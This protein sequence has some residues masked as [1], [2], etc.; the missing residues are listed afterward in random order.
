MKQTVRMFARAKDLAGSDSV[1][2][3]TEDE[4]TVA[5][6]KTLLAEQY[7]ELE[8]MIPHL[9]IAVDMNYVSDSDIITENSEIAC[10]PPVSGG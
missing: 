1:E 5:R 10:F 2:I 3:E 7:P 6:L 9:L 4:L 8:P